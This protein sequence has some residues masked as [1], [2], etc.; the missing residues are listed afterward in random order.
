MA[1]AELMNTDLSEE[2]LNLMI[3]QD[4]LRITSERRENDP[5]M[6]ET[7]A[8][9]LE[10]DID[11]DIY[12]EEGE[13]SDEENDLEE[14]ITSEDRA[15]QIAGEVLSSDTAFNA[16]GG[17]PYLPKGIPTPTATEFSKRIGTQILAA[18]DDAPDRPANEPIQSSAK[19]GS[20]VTLLK[21]Y[22]SR[23]RGG[24]DAEQDLKSGHEKA[25]DTLVES[26]PDDHDT[27]DHLSRS[28]RLEQCLQEFKDQLSLNEGATADKRTYPE[29]TF[30]L[31]SHEADLVLEARLI[32][33]SNHLKTI[34]IANDLILTSIADQGIKLSNVM[35]MTIEIP[36]ISGNV[37]RM[38]K[39]INELV[40]RDVKQRMEVIE[41]RKQVSE[42]STTVQ[43]LKNSIAL[44]HSNIMEAVTNF[45]TIVGSLKEKTSPGDR[46][47]VVP[48]SDATPDNTS[49]QQS[50]G[51]IK[52][53][54]KPI[55]MTS[56]D[57]CICIL[58]EIAAR[59]QLGSGANSYV[60]VLNAV[61]AGSPLDSLLAL[62]KSPYN[63]Q[64]VRRQIELIAK[65]RTESCEELSPMLMSIARAVKATMDAEISSI[66]KRSITSPQQ[67]SASNTPGSSLWDSASWM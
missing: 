28:I 6:I 22:Q 10:Q 26:D 7:T 13:N 65:R 27:Q 56:A 42:I 61:L 12:S 62:S 37:E 30:T 57:K 45:S 18:A 54:A 11:T 21:K 1:Y 29:A 4:N 8:G 58:K 49:P 47:V 60:D 17:N 16:N 34:D 41:I 67:Q 44:F 23:L 48:Q 55:P 24:S 36:A 9:F 14:L 52:K 39:H 51:A 3:E 59:E 20:K 40:S 63:I 5:D 43:E 32:F 31:D 64:S 46:R 66:N 19:S 38:A 50:K 2:S 15:E 25:D 35:D 53:V 33:L